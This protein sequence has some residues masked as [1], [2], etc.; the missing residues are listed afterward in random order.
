MQRKILNR[1]T[2][3]GADDSVN[4]RY[5]LEISQE[6]PWVEWGILLSKNQ[7]NTKRFPSKEWVEYLG[8]QIRRFK[9]DKR[10]NNVNANFSGHLCGSWLRQLLISN[11]PEIFNNWVSKYFY[12]FDRVQ[13]NWH[14]EPQTINWE[15]FKNNIEKIYLQRQIIFQID[16]V[17][18]N[19]FLEAENK[20]SLGVIIPFY[21]LSHG[22]GIL[23]DS[24]PKNIGTSIFY[25]YG[26]GLTPYNLDEELEKIEQVLTSNSSVWIDVETGVR[27]NSYHSI[28][29][30][31]FNLHKVWKFLKI[32]E[33]YIQNY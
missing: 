4:P 18:N 27:G 13:F 15:I 22:T 16:Q 2:I 31:L 3:T 32:A 24:W 29:D 33:K 1:V 10:F 14:G 28:G 9:N 30:E 25:G 20:F 17:N 7:Q 5:L 8:Q 19:L 11:K 6:F 21:D 12:L 26:G 23:P